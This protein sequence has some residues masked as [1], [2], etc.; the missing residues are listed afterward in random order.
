MDTILKDSPEDTLK[1]A[2]DALASDATLTPYEPGHGLP[3]FIQPKTAKIYDNTEYAIAW[4][5]E[6]RPII[7]QALSAAGA[8]V[9]RGFPIDR[10][11]HFAR[12]MRGYGTFDNGYVGGVA[13]RET[14]VENVMTANN[15]RS[16]LVIDIHQEM[17]YL[18]N[19]PKRIAFYCRVPPVSAGATLICD[20]RKASKRIDPGLFNEVKK[21]GIQHIRNY[22]APGSPSP[23]PIIGRYHK[24]WS[25]AFSTDDPKTAEENCRKIGLNT[26]WCDDGSLETFYNVPG[27]ITH[28]RTG[29]DIWFNQVT[30]YVHT[31]RVNPDLYYL[32]EEAYPKGKRRPFVST[33]GDGAEIPI[34]LLEPI[35]PM[36]ADI[37]VAFPWSRGDIL[38]IDNY[39]V[40]HGR[41]AFTG[42][43]NI[44]VALLGG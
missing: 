3:L 34:D 21:R 10:S 7:E 11:V 26:R 27:V 40:G 13:E 18:P 30:T 14:I 44:Q 19:Y 39:L 32:H 41:A 38:L 22:R 29:E 2:A 15:L 1:A 28:P 25:E 37:S 31:P 17:A 36:L 6:H 8:I 5:D 12:V 35:K 9:L 24:I 42:E 33:Y 20:M 16:D 4:L 23:H 43:R